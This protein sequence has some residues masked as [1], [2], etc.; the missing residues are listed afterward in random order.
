MNSNDSVSEADRLNFAENG[1]V[2]AL[3]IG[4]K[5]IRKRGFHR[6]L[7]RGEIWARMER[8]LNLYANEMNNA[9]FGLAPTEKDRG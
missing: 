3:K 9:L 5:P 1:E 6:A 2:R 4:G 7:K 8:V